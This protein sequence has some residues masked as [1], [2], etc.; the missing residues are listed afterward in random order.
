[1]CVC[2]IIINDI[3]IIIELMITDQWL[4]KYYYDVIMIL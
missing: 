1:M 4:M 3:I 2:N